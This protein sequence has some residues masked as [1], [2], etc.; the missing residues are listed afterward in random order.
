MAHKNPQ[1]LHRVCKQRL[2]VFFGANMRRCVQAYKAQSIKEQDSYQLYYSYPVK[3]E[4]DS[5]QFYKLCS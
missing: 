3:K 1:T 2:N 4:Q 5:C